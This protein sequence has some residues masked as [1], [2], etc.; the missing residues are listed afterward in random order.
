MPKFRKEKG[1]FIVES[2][3]RERLFRTLHDAWQY[4][5]YLRSIA[6]YYG[7]PTKSPEKPLYPADSLLPPTVERTVKFYD[8]DAQE[9]VLI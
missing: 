9:G 8:L 1:S 7:E 5:F 4:I 6:R 2:D 3:G